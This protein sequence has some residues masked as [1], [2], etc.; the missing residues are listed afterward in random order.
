MSEVDFRIKRGCFMKSSESV[1]LQN[2]TFILVIG[3]DCRGTFSL[4]PVDATTDP[5]LQ[6]QD[7]RYK[8]ILNSK[9]DLHTVF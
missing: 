7:V 5:L 4:N 1:V 2:R 9:Q 6:L 3:S 8:T